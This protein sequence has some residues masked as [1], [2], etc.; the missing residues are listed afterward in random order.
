[1]TTSGGERAEHVLHSV[2]NDVVDRCVDFFRRADGSFGYREFRRDPEDQGR[3]SLTAAYDLG[4]HA[5]YPD[6]LAA[7]VVHISWLAAAVARS[8]PFVP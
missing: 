2:H 7:A 3:W 8:A 6:A 5:D 1:M 4:V